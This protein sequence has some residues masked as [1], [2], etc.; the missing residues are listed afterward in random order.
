MSK[1]TVTSDLKLDNTAAGVRHHWVCQS[2]TF[3]QRGH[4]IFIAFNTIK[5]VILLINY[6]TIKFSVG[7]LMIMECFI[8]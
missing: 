8:F 4:G 3:S 1:N 5:F 2:R 7:D 6:P